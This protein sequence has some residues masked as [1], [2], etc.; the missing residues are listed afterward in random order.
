MKLNGNK[1]STF[2]EKKTKNMFGIDHRL[3]LVYPRTGV[4]ISKKNMTRGA[5]N[6]PYARGR[7]NCYANK[8]PI[9]FLVK[10]RCFFLKRCVRG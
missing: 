9:L 2:E 7:G 4:G 8:Q 1:K 3:G 10:L 6:F 5:E